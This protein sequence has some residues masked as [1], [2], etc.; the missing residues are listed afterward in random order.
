MTGLF[1]YELNVNGNYAHFKIPYITL[2]EN[3]KTLHLH[4]SNSNV[5]TNEVYRSL[6]SQFD[7]IL[8][9]RLYG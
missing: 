3:M 8:E 4:C 9:N 6:T 2:N 7:I 1:I 5:Q